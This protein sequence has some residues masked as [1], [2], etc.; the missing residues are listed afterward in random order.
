M[1]CGRIRRND[2]VSNAKGGGPL[3]AEGVAALR[4]SGGDRLFEKGT[5]LGE[6]KKGRG[7]RQK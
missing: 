5:D 3:Q 2:R 1:T 4:A 6:G 7:V